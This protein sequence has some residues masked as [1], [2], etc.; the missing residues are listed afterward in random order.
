MFRGETLR[1]LL[2]YAWGWSVVGEI[3][4]WVGIASLLGAFVILAGLA[5]GYMTP[6]PQHARRGGDRLTQAQPS[7]RVEPR[8][9]G[10]PLVGGDAL[11]PSGT[12]TMILGHEPTM[13]ERHTPRMQTDVLDADECQ[14]LLRS[15]MLGR[16]GV[17]IDALPAILPVNFVIDRGA[18]MF[19]IAPGTKID[20]ATADAVVAFEVDGHYEHDG[21]ESTWS[22]LVRGVAQ[23][24]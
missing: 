21:T 15:S 11:R 17:T 9:T 22:V 12:R 10:A 4:Y 8:A 2:L 24:S 3:A 23:A 14:R 20:A 1:G 19:R 18:I 6:P 16:L 7:T 5:I 13:P